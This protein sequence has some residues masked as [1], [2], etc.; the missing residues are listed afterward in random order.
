M[1]KPN[2]VAKSGPIHFFTSYERSALIASVVEYCVQVGERQPLTRTQAA[3]LVAS[4]QVTLDGTTV[5]RL[6]A[7]V[8]DGT[9]RLGVRGKDHHVVIHGTLK[10]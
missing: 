1:T 4:G 7:L 9:W 8:P 6:G 2:D 10:E 5:T 3:H